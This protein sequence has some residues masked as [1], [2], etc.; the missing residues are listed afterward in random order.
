MRPT[1]AAVLTMARSSSPGPTSAGEFVDHSKFLGSPSPAYYFGEK[2]PT[3]PRPSPGCSSA[4]KE[5]LLK[6]N[7]PQN[8]SLRA[9]HLL[10]DVVGDPVQTRTPTDAVETYGNVIAS[11]RW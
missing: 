3:P 7:F 9:A 2:A 4:A 5:P 1:A 8:L 10:V 11:T 6:Q